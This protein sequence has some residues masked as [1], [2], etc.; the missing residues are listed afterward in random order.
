MAM[1][2]NSEVVVNGVT[3]FLGVI[4]GK[5]LD[6]GTMFILEELDTKNGNAAGTRTTENKCVD[7][8]LVKNI[9]DR[10]VSFP[11]KFKLVYERQV[12]KGGERLIVIDA[13]SMG[14]AHMPFE[15]KA[16]D[17]KAA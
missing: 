9:L 13:Q 7:S 10:G 17:T 6:S 12:T 14:S 11:S 5:E 8:A 2:F 16:Q 4:D 1:Q 15:G 3:Y